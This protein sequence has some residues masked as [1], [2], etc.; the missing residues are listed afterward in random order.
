MKKISLI[1]LI[2]FIFGLSGAQLCD[3]TWNKPQL[4]SN[5]SISFLQ[6]EPDE[7]TL[8]A[9]EL[10][11]PPGSES[12]FSFALSSC[13]SFKN[14]WKNFF[15][16]QDTSSFLYYRTPDKPEI[17]SGFF[18][19]NHFSDDRIF[20]SLLKLNLYSGFE[21]SWQEKGNYSFLYYGTRL[22]GFLTKRL[23]FSGHWWAGH[24]SGDLEQA[25]NSPLIDSWFKYSKDNSKI[26]LDNV[27]G[28]I[29]YRGKGDFWSLSAGRGKHEIGSNIGGSIILN[30]DCNDYGYFSSKFVFPNFYMSYLHAALIPDST[31]FVTS[32]SFS[33]KF[34]VI[35]KFGWTPSSKFELFAGEEII[36][37]NRSLDLNYMLPQLF[38]RAVEH[39][40]GDRD[41]ALIFLGLNFR[42]Q[43][44]TLFYFN[45]IL[46]ELRKAEIFSNWWGNK[47]A[48][49]LGGSFTF[50]QERD[51]IVSLEF[52]AVRP[53]LYTHYILEN[54]YSHYDISLGFP[55][56]SNL[57]QYSCELNYN[58]FS[59]V[60]FNLNALYKRQGSVGNS[61][62][63]NY[64]SRPSDQ[65]G[66]LEGKITD[67]LVLKPVLT[68]QMLAHHHLKAGILI[69][70]EFGNGKEK[71]SDSEFYFS[72]QALY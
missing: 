58:I 70:Q 11:R 68:W 35:H 64:N 48:F 7:D 42:P 51:G 39:N 14:A 28:R 19:E 67:T 12:Q 20:A 31:G 17:H 47:Y 38:W 45:F 23:F 37:S 3:L 1:I 22:S 21:H 62:N 9:A 43:K 16:V 34:M 55:S 4:S 40:L 49:Q 26:Y 15:S 44:F 72:Y 61:F 30:D 59:T 41:N 53:W 60:N 8:F 50:H 57:L 46:D 13:T 52:T 27:S 36:Y 6:D 18:T 33:D 29:S 71:V 5:N 54:K 56:G 66:W 65:A 25:A 10:S 24:F 69:Q 2:N 63:L 32:P